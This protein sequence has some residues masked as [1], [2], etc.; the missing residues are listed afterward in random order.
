[1][2]VTTSDLYDPLWIYYCNNSFGSDE[3]ISYHI[4]NGVTS[5]K[6]ATTWDTSTW[7]GAT[8]FI[9]E[10]F[11][12]LDPLIDLDFSKTS[13][14]KDADIVIYMISPF[15]NI[16]DSP[17]TIG[18]TSFNNLDQIEVLWKEQDTNFTTNPFMVEPYGIL[19]FNEAY[20]ITHEIGHAL[21]LGH[22][23][24]DP[25]GSWH[26]ST[27]TVMSYNVSP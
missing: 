21:G 18:T 16:D 12:D 15:T 25:S 9:D 4:Y 27:D 11:S 1:M 7:K 22:P 14:A 13:K 2:P 26:N 19:E 5:K 6:G 20:A 24:N 23:G 17:N 3:N 10:V 8:T